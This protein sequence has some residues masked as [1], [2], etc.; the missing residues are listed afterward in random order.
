MQLITT[1][2]HRGS[3]AECI[4]CKRRACTNKLN[5]IECSETVG[6]QSLASMFLSGTWNVVGN[7][8]MAL[9]AQRVLP[10]HFW[11]LSSP[12][13]RSTLMGL[14]GEVNFGRRACQKSRDQVLLCVGDLP[15]GVAWESC[16]MS[17]KDLTL[18]RPLTY[19]V[20]YVKSDWLA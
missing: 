15:W 6:K 20:S 1:A 19:G 16:R 3:W 11:S 12:D 13:G 5:M 9:Q 18:H 8:G 14:M 17:W 2:F 4:H 10:V 7:F